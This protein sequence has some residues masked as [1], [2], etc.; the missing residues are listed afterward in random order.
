MILIRWLALLTFSAAVNAQA[1]H[2]HAGHP[3]AEPQ[4]EAALPK[5]T[6]PETARRAEEPALSSTQDAD[7]AA[8]R[9][10][11]HMS[12]MMHGDT[13]NYLLLGERLEFDD[14][15]FNWEAQGWI[16]RDLDKLWIKTEGHYERTAQTTE[17]A[18]IQ[19]LYS[20]AI[21]PWWDL[22]AGL[23]H[24]DG[25]GPARSYVAVGLLGLAPYWFEI[26]SAL[27]LSERGD[28]SVRMEAEYELRFTQKLL[29]QPRV[30]LNYSF[31][32]DPA[33]RIG[34]GMSA[35][36]VGLRLRYEFR[37]EFAPYLG[38]EWRR[39]Y[40]ATAQLLQSASEPREEVTA[41]AGLRLWY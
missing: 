41:V 30:E 21:A 38:V 18:E 16:G 29:L 34:K 5:V 24:A 8:L 20:R 32:D 23:R 37:R 33:V 4:P 9:E 27:F 1:Q 13:V 28:L 40:G 35:A 31:A 12:R 15:A 2:E 17:Q 3:G 26:D 19:A 6:Q 39:A 14:A 7:S 10:A 22:Q 25:A 11:R 36:S